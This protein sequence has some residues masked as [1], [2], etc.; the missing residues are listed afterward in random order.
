MELKQLNFGSRNQKTAFEEKMFIPCNNEDSEYREGPFLSLNAKL[1]IVIIVASSIVTTIFT[2][3]SFYHDYKRAIKEVDEIVN[4]IEKTYLESVTLATFEFNDIQLKTLLEGMA[5]LPHIH[6]VSVIDD[7]HRLLAASKAKHSSSNN[8]TN[9]WI[10]DYFIEPNK[11][12]RS[13]TFNLV[14]HDEISKTKASLGTLDLNYSLTGVYLEVINRAL[15]FFITQGIKTFVVSIIILYFCSQIVT[16]PIR[17]IALY[18]DGYDKGFNK[19]RR[20]LNIGSRFLSSKKDEIDVLGSHIH[21]MDHRL[22]N[23]VDN[24]E[25]LIEERNKELLTKNQLLNDNLTKI[26]DMQ[27]IMIANEK[28]ASLGQL[29]AGVAHEIKNPLN[30][31][32][33]SQEIIT[34]FLET[35]TEDRLRNDIKDNDLAEFFDDY[36]DIREASSMI[37]EGSLRIDGI[38]KTMLSN[39]R[40]NNDDFIEFDLSEVIQ[41]NYKLVYKSLQ[42]NNRITINT[43]INLDNLGTISGHPGD[44]GRV[45]LNLFENAI[46][47]LKQ[48]YDSD[49]TFKPEIS[50]LGEIVQDQIII[51]VQ[52]NGLGIPPSVVKKVLDPFFTTKPTNEGTGLGLFLSFDIIRAHGGY[53]EVSSEEGL[54]TEIKLTFTQTRKEKSA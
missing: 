1:L 23:I 9:Q 41:T 36:D 11:Q 33:S 48:K 13:K 29:S 46:Y 35:H 37:E 22:R 54:G 39:S 45:F 43:N 26:Q 30:F 4:L 25:S 47:S 34:S 3:I 32:K 8:T 10:L 7:Q 6:D 12:V 53:L 42:A 52:D 40:S 15:Y 50:I 38:V 17:K 49:P 28:L 51:K 14:F 18:F 5:A 2:S 44:I 31:I 19:A 27:E 24:L 21:D 20:D 16:K